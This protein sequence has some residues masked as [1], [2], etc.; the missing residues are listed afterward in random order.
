MR[1]LVWFRSDLRVSDNTALHRAA[2]VSTRGVIAVFVISPAQWK[3]HDWAACR[4][5]LMLR[6]LRE[7]SGALKATNIPLLIVRAERFSDV[8]AA[9]LKVAKSH[10]CD[11]LYYNIEYEINESRRDDAVARA[12]AKSGLAVHALHDQTVFPPESIRTGQGTFYTVF[13]PFKKSWLKRADEAGPIKLLSKPRKQDGAGVEPD[14]V[15]EQVKGFESKIPADLWPAG[16]SA[17]QKRLG[18]FVEMRAQA[19]A[20]ARNTPAIDGTSTLSAYLAIG[21]ISSR[22]CI[23][24]A[25][26]S[27]SGQ[28]GGDKNGPSTW[29]SE[30]IW[31]EFY[32]HILVGF[33]RVCMHQP[34]KAA[35]RQ[36]RW[37]ENEAGCEAWCAGRTGFPIVDAGMRQLHATGW[38]HNRVRM[39][40]AMFLTKDLFIDWRRGERYF[41]QHLIDGDLANN[42]G[43]WQWSAS[44]GT[45]AAPYFRI[46]NPTS[47]SKSNDAKGEYI[48]TWVPELK[49]L[50]AEEIHDPSPLRRESLGYPMPIVDHAASRERVMREF[51]RIGAGE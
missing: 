1:A 39:I 35:T 33:P 3:E 14:D 46:F 17:A 15:P 38:M 47:Q 42:N 41:M 18:Q 43:G 11:A 29:I 36:I 49:K 48:R 12:A 32:R 51:T 19:Y 8:P 9:L 13:T 2:S 7:L 26:E 10:A 23:A 28:L 30:V 24:A 37:A 31:R 50:D 34:F 6:T 20:A 16:E 22:Q 45:D 44:T 27:N 4:V 5:D 40:T 21:A 25:A